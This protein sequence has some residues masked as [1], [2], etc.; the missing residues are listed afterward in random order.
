MACVASRLPFRVNLAAACAAVLL[1]AGSGQIALAQA[2]APPADEEAANEEAPEDADGGETTGDEEPLIAP[3][4][5]A[6]AQPAAGSDGLEAS[7]AVVE[8]YIKGQEYPKTPEYVN[9][10]ASAVG[11][12]GKYA[13]LDRVDARRQIGSRMSSSTRKLTDDKLREIEQMMKDGDELVYTDPR[14]AIEILDQAKT[15]LMMIMETI[16]LNQKIRKDFFMTQML[17]ARSHYDN[18][19]REKAGT[20]M[21]EIIR[22]FGED[23]KVTDDEYHPDIVALYREKYRTLSEQRKGKVTVRTEPPGAEVLINGKVQAQPSP[24]T[25]DGLYPG[26][27]TVAAR[28][29]GRES[30]I[31][32]IEIGLDT[33]AEIRIDIDYE[34]A[35]A[36]DQEHFGF[37]FGDEQVLKRRVAD[38]GSRVGAMLAVDYVLVT[39]LIEREGRTYLEGY[40]VNVSDQSVE[41]HQGFYTKA[42][43]V[44]NNRVNQLARFVADAEYKAPEP[45]YKPWYTNWIGW[46][47]T[48]A[49]VASGGVALFFLSDFTTKADAVERDWTSKQCSDTYGPSHQ[50]YTT[51]QG[52]LNKAE[53]AN[54]SSTVAGVL[55]GVAGVSLVAGILIFVLV[56]EEDPDATA[57]LDLDTPKLQYVGPAMMP[58]NSP[59]IGFGLTF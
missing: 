52:L 57:L 46:T 49:A 1:V 42:N 39:G 17:L 43:V 20:I 29:D 24:A 3:E 44:S 58:G 14:R 10:V 16:S 38:F 26:H 48:G 53:R 47:L 30:M 51:C 4:A 59:G 2:E 31:R 27:V 6:A 13:M 33:P 25:Y 32:K 41:R 18:G 19:N 21:E 28:K 55:A 37:R 56:E 50:L 22:V 8:F 34:T 9:R 35:L 7:L 12:L 23:E 40:L 36:F 11:A 54:T 5:P 45:V 15:E